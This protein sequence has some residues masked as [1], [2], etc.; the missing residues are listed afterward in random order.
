[1][2]SAHSVARLTQLPIAG[3]SVDAVLL[4]HTLEFEADPYAVL[5]EADRVLTG[6]GKLLVLGFRPWSL[7]GLRSRI[8]RAGFPPGQRRLLGERRLRDWLVL[9]G[10]E[11]DAPRHYLFELPWGEPADPAHSLR[12]SLLHP[13]PAGAYLLKARKRIYALPPQRLRLR[14][15]ARA[16]GGVPSPAANRQ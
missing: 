15:R 5:R 3:D 1:V 7:W 12:R 8:S 13:L 2:R 10:Y 6:E 11:V 16:I 9:L 4:P 14:E